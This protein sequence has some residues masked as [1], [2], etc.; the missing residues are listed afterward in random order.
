MGGLAKGWRRRDVLVCLV[1]VVSADAHECGAG[2]QSPSNVPAQS[3][4][5][6]MLS[7]IQLQR[8]LVQSVMA[9]ADALL[10]QQDRLIA[11]MTVTAPPQAQVDPPDPVQD[12]PEPT[13]FLSGRPI[14]RGR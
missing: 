2:Q 10:D 13:H 9:Q 5:N 12:D 3:W 7:L 1:A 4:L 11:T 8:E 6:V 14:H